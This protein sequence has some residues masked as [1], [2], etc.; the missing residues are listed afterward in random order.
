MAELPN[1]KLVVHPRGAAHM[2]DPSRLVAG[3]TAVYGEEEMQR[4]YGTIVPVPEA[5]VVV[6]ADGDV[7]D[8][9]GLSLIHI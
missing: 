1:A 5:R 9:Q 2:I 7:F 8:L 6:A 3:A 4:S